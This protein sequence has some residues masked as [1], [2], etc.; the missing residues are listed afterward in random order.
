LLRYCV[1][2]LRELQTVMRKSAGEATRGSIYGIDSGQ[3]A[4]SNSKRLELCGQLCSPRSRCGLPIRGCMQT[5]GCWIDGSEQPALE[6]LRPI[7]S[8]DEMRLIRG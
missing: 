4:D 3:A 2:L 5:P 6:A 1:A 7:V 8:V